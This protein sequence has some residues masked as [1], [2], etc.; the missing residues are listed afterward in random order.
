MGGPAVFSIAFT[1][2]DLA[3]FCAQWERADG[4]SL[5]PRF[6]LYVRRYSDWWERRGRHMP[7][8][9]RPE[10]PG[11]SVWIETPLGI[12]THLLTD[13]EQDRHPSRAED[14]WA[15][16]CQQWPELQSLQLEDLRYGEVAR[17][18][19]GEPPWVLL[20]NAPYMLLASNRSED[21]WQDIV[22]WLRLPEG[23]HVTSEI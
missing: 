1:E 17:G 20:W 8:L 7:T 18:Y 3:A 12:M 22:E 15:N 19:K 23:T 21:I 10:H 6:Q 2:A 9:S 13:E 5:D 11:V 14:I 16:A 4:A